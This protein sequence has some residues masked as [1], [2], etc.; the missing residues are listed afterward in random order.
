[1][2]RTPPLCCVVLCCVVLCGVVVW[3]GV[4]WCGVVCRCGVCSRYSWVRP[5]FGAPPDSSSVD[6][7]SVDS[8]SAGPPSAGPP[9]FRFFFPLSRHNFLSFFPLF[10]VLSL[11]FGG[12]FEGRDPEMCTFGL[13]SCRV[14]PQRLLGRRGFIRQPENS[15]RAH[16]RALVLQTTPKFHEGPPREEERK[17]HVAGE[18]KKARNFAPPTLLGPTLRG[19]TLRG[20]N[21]KQP[22]SGLGQKWSGH[23]CGEMSGTKVVWAKSGICPRGQG[24][25]KKNS[26]V[27]GD[28]LLTES[29]N[30]SR[31]YNAL[32]RGH[33]F[34]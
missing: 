11:N 14:K 22:K 6:S 23:K 9:K 31:S 5:R 28:T 4:V 33:P 19:T 8:S 2:R 1:M 3:C 12:V 17:K 24:F 15:K 7:P 25:K 27:Q 26:T 13:S 18:G 10:R 20:T 30:T 32:R 21:R 29:E 16:F 34:S